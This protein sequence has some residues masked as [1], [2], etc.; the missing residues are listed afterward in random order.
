ML[1]VRLC[2]T[3]VGEVAILCLLFLLKLAKICTVSGAVGKVN[4]QVFSPSARKGSLVRAATSQETKPRL[5]LDHWDQ[6]CGW[7]AAGLPGMKDALHSTRVPDTLVLTQACRPGTPE[8]E[9][10]RGQAHGHPGLHSE[11]KDSFMLSR[12]CLNRIRGREKSD[13]TVESCCSFYALKEFVH[14]MEG[15]ACHH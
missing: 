13:W 1:F 9:A 15:L 4:E 10:G 14:G 6:C 2:L 5:L 3:R 12:P 7:L 8:V 11:L